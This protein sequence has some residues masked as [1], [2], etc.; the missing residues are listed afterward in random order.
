MS[1][2]EF[3]IEKVLLILHCS[4][5]IGNRRENPNRV[6]IENIFYFCSLFRGISSVG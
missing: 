4:L 6:T 5:L 1:N 3:L 2:E